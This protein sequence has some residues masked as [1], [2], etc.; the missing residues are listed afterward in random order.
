MTENTSVY[1]K[2]KHKG[3]EEKIVYKERK[4]E[5]IKRSL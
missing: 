2:T 1:K 3:M 4:R 5:A